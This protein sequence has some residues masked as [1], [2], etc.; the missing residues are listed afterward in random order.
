VAHFP[1]FPESPLFSEPLSSEPQ[2]H[3]HRYCAV[4]LNL[5]LFRYFHY[6]VP[7]KLQDRIAIGKRVKVPFRHRVETGFCVEFVQTPEVPKVLD[8]FEVLDTEVLVLPS[9]M[10][11]AQWI[12]K[13]Y[14][15]SLGDVLE[16]FL[17]RAV[18]NQIQ[19]K[20]VPWISTTLSEKELEEHIQTLQDEF[21]QQARF[22]RAL[23]DLPQKEGNPHQLTRSLGLSLSPV[24]SLK[25]KGIIQWTRKSVPLDP[26][27]ELLTVSP[28]VMKL[29]KEQQEALSQL[30]PLL[31]PGSFSVTLLQGVT[32]SGKT[33]IYLRTIQKVIDRGQ[34]AIVMVPE[35]ALTPQTVARFKQRFAR[36]ALLH[37]QLTDSQRYSQWTRIYQEE[38]DVVIGPRSAIFAPLRR[39]GLVVIDEEHEMTFK[40]QNAPYY[41]ARDVAIVRAKM[42]G[43]AV[44]L[45]TATPS[46]ETYHKALQ[47]KYH[48]IFLKNRVLYQSMPQVSLIHMG[49][50]MRT[51]RRL[52]LI[53]QALKEA[54]ETALQRKE[55]VI[56]FLNRRG[57]STYVDCKRCGWILK[58]ISCDVTMTFHKKINRALCHYCY[59]EQ[60]PPQSCPA[61]H[62]PMVRYLGTGTE[63]IE[64][65]TQQVFPTARI[66]RMD[67]DSMRAGNAYQRI[68]T[69]FQ[70]REID[71]LIGT[72]MIAKGL[73]FHNITLVGVIQADSALNFP[74]FRA[75]ERTFQ[76]ICQV[77]GRTGRGG[78]QGRVIIQTF[79]PEHYAIHYASRHNYT[80]FAKEE[81]QFRETLGY[82]PYGY[83]L[84]ILVRGENLEAVALHSENIAENLRRLRLEG[85][86]ILGPAPAP[87]TRIKNKHRF[88]ILAKSQ[89]V[90]KL[91]RLQMKGRTFL[92]SKGDIQCAI[93]I[94]PL[95]ML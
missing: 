85:V 39:L 80:G 51:Q 49:D 70:N 56:F 36:V 47:K 26:F 90:A 82:P 9:L 25:K 83:L 3:P 78:K 50:E 94:D 88:Q 41:H 65:V 37:S 84:R 31:E 81:L 43:A 46:L 12:S 68:L 71:I 67:G 2:E 32:G 30:E 29:T 76:L 4:A 10:Q 14:C 89:T 79:Q 6:Q 69:Q 20:V 16:A 54:T 34:Q 13:Y 24:Q 21:P 57:F 23:K 44:I 8:I 7:P 19:S 42:E 61:C 59:H 95:A 64:E 86:E 62:F 22:L 17:P 75:A 58:C 91:Q 18:K 53:S 15:C 92:A 74:D 73:D 40:Q 87:I 35:I 27:A 72:Q 1:E 45:G 28:P 93:D 11:L 66:A 48:H 5:P 55:Q 52:T 77:S 33:E 38:I 63:K 60:T